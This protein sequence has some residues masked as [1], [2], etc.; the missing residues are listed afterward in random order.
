MKRR[1]LHLIVA[2]VP[3]LCACAIVMVVY[4]LRLQGSVGHHLANADAARGR[5]EWSLAILHARQAAQAAPL[6]GARAGYER[7]EELAE[8]AQARADWDT[9]VSANL[10]TLDAARAAR[11]ALFDAAGFKARARARLVDVSH[12]TTQARSRAPRDS[13]RELD[14]LERD[15][16][17]SPWASG[18]L[19]ALFV[20]FV[21]SAWRA[22]RRDRSS[23][24]APAWAVWATA[25]AFVALVFVEALA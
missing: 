11:G 4:V 21:A 8:E 22:L 12:V 14:D 2:M 20:A 18:A 23:R 5:G 24:Y 3:A 25:V 6:P 15:D 17:R 1:S 9:A 7:L 13:G 10:G 19:G 16:A